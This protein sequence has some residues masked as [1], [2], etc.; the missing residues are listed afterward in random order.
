M[1]E[2][3]V[4]LGN[5]YRDRITGFLGIAVSRTEFLYG[6][7]R[8]CLEKGDEKGEKAITEY[9][10][11]QRLDAGGGVVKSQPMLVSE[12]RTGGPGDVPTAWHGER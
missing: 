5:T 1:T 2:S 4:T 9:F 6:C 12:A 11:E 3:R 7:V 8:V 10:D